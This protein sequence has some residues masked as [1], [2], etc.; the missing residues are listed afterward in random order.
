[1]HKVGACLYFFVLL[2][3]YSLFHLGTGK[4]TLV[5]KLLNERI[6]NNPVPCYYWSL[7]DCGSGTDFMALFLSHFGVKKAVSEGRLAKDAVN[8]EVLAD[9]FHQLRVETKA[10]CVLVIDDAQ[11]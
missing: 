3:I 5:Q 10:P 4:T 11:V 1:M 8:S 2:E 6:A 9:V 7:K